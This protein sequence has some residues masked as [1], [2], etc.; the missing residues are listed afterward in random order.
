MLVHNPDE[1]IYERRRRTRRRP[2]EKKKKREREK[3]ENDWGP[4]LAF[5]II[6]P[7]GV[8]PRRGITLR[9]LESM[10]QKVALSLSFCFV[11]FFFFN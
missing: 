7:L 9:D 3:K 4:S 2:A 6:I 11:V 8:S 5:T 10:S 1:I